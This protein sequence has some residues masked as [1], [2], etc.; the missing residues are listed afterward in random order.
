MSLLSLAQAQLPIVT[1]PANAPPGTPGWHEK[2]LAHDGLTRW[3]LVYVPENLPPRAPVVLLLHGGTGG[4]RGIFNTNQSTTREWPYLAEREKFVLYVPNGV[5]PDTG[6]TYGDQQNWNDLRDPNA[7]RDSEEDDVGFLRKVIDDAVNVRNADPLRVYF[8]GSSN[9]G[10]MT[11]RMAME[12]TGRMAAAAIAIANLPEYDTLYSE[13][14]RPVPFMFI[15]GTAD[16]LM[17]YGGSPG[18]VIS[19]PATVA[20]WIQ[21][22]NANPVAAENFL[23]PDLDPADQC[24]IRRQ[25]HPALPGGAPVAFLTVEGGGHVTPSIKH[26]IPQSPVVIRLIGR[27]CHDAESA[28]L[29]W[30]FLSRF[31]ISLDPRLTLTKS[32]SAPPGTNRFQVNLTGGHPGGHAVLERSFT[33]GDPQWTVIASAPLDDLGAVPFEWAPSSETKDFVRARSHPGAEPAP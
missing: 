30:E 29:Q 4:M 27:Q 20:W 15:N 28:E 3:F 32:A 10:T 14:A 12:A 25:N 23:L 13:P 11:M 5:N 1:L 21:R 8:T 6:D 33:L 18:G 31:S 16:P 9:G 24:R 22:N 17:V 26:H 2:S 19:A 7:D